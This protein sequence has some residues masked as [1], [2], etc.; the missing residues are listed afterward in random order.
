MMRDYPKAVFYYLKI[1]ATEKEPILD[2]ACGTGV[3]TR[4]LVRL[5]F[6]DV[7]GVDMDPHK[8]YEAREHP[9]F[10]HISYFEAPYHNLPFRNFAFK[11]ATC[12]ASSPAL[13]TEASLAE[14]K[15]VLK[16][17]GVLFLVSKSDLDK[18]TED[19]LKTVEKYVG[20]HFAPPLSPM[21]LLQNK[22][23]LSSP[24]GFEGEEVFSLQEAVA[25]VQSLFFWRELTQEEQFKCLD[26]AV[27]PHLQGKLIDGKILRRYDAM[28]LAAVKT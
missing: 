26:N 9:H 28:C 3:S 24:K 19:I 22:F 17:S 10:K 6:E 1:Y 23:Q 13:F 2:I 27:L 21:N 16:R 8:L 25:Y 4:Q 20:R 5:G 7:Q 14:V 11:A 18:F 12:F 15:R